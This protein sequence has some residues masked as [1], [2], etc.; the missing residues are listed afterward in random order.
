MA[1]TERSPERL[2]AGRDKL[3]S[4]KVQLTAAIEHQLA[5][6]RSGSTH[7]AAADF[8]WPR[9]KTHSTAAYH[10]KD[11]ACAARA[12]RL[13]DGAHDDRLMIKIRLGYCIRDCVL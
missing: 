9:Y 7:F 4:I 11:V 3:E 13:N 6:F 10:C 2:N 12:L 1:H 5:R 8:L